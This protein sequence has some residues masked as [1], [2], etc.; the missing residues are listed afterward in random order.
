MLLRRKLVTYLV[1]G[2]LLAFFSV[3]IWPNPGLYGMTDTNSASKSLTLEEAIQLAYKRNPEAK[4]ADLAVEQTEIIRDRAAQAVIFSLTD[5]LVTPVY[6]Q[7]FNSYQQAEI[8]WQAAKKAQANQMDLV[9]KNVITAYSKAIKD[10]NNLELARLSLAKL[11]KQAAITK[12]SK[13]LGMISALDWQTLERGIKQAEDSVKAAEANYLSS[14]LALITLTGQN[15]N[16]DFELVSRPLFD[17][18]PKDSLDQ[19]CSRA[20][21]DGVLVWRA[22][23]QLEIEKSKEPWDLPDVTSKEKKLNL[24]QAELDYEIAKRDTR[25]TVESLYYG[26]DALERQIQV[27]KEADILAQEKLRIAE[28]KYRV[29]ILPLVSITPGQ[30]DLMSARVAAEKSRADLENLRA[31]LAKLKADFYYV[32]G[33]T[34]YESADWSTGSGSSIDLQTVN[35]KPQTGKRISFTVG[36]PTYMNGDDIIALDTP[37]YIKS[38][39][40]Y[41]P[42]RAL[43]ESLGAVVSWDEDTRTV[44][45]T[46]G[47]DR[48][49]MKIGDYNIKVNGSYTTMEVVPEITG[50]RTMLPARYVAEAFGALISWDERNQEV[51]IFR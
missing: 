18:I 7:V 3:S 24:N 25:S 1:G 36:A 5:G 37:A 20:I 32:T 16:T 46:R 14:R 50:G 34:V 41:L 33:R 38:G 9:S 22:Q 4:K 48:V 45:L 15:S 17:E 42:V 43:G 27:A 26:I 47:E 51:V 23:Q 28:I 44:T 6:Q 10:F 13:E 40:T 19:E 11:Q 12:T 49:E 29:G 8:A 31:D 35:Y 39:R 30:E 2:I 21:D